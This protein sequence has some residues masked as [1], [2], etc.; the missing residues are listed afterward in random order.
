[1]G[2]E[3]M[4]LCLAGLPCGK[5]MLIVDN[6]R[7]KN[8]DL[9]KCQGDFTWGIIPLTGSD[10]AMVLHFPPLFTTIIVPTYM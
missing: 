4:T 2:F 10:P 9:S 8:L 1:M 7:V 3:N 6:F 5:I